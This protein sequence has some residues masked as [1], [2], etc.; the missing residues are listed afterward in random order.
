MYYYKLPIV[1]CKLTNFQ[2]SIIIP[3]L[4]EAENLA[5]LLPDIQQKAAGKAVEIIVIDGGSRDQTIEIAQR[6]GAKAMVSPRG[7]R[8]AQMNFGATVAQSNVLYFVH[9][10]GRLPTRF[11]EDIEQA[12]ATGYEA[13]CYRFRFDSE[14]F[15]LKINGFCTRFNALTFRGGDQTLF[16]SRSLFEAIGGFDEHYVIMED[17]DIIRR[18]W[19]K[20]RQL[21]KVI[22]KDVIVS[23]RKYE[24]NSWLRVQLA[25]LR[26]MISFNQNKPP[27]E[28]AKQYK[29]MLNYR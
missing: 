13:G 24:T 3:A 26:A 10:D 7:G 14:A 25:N 6:L 23:A 2:L 12:V 22:Q 11:V 8:A 29:K 28:I 20:N 1:D 9:A 19:A 21:F 16:I 5:E 18:I 17:Y 4:N 27:Q 15:M